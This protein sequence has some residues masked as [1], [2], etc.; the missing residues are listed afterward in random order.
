MVAL[1]GEA[2]DVLACIRIE[3]VLLLAVAKTVWFVLSTIGASS[4]TPGLAP[5]A[6]D[7]LDVAQCAPAEVTQ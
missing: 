6:T 2:N 1:T 7:T 3:L 4:T 5:E